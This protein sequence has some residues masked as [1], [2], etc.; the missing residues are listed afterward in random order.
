MRR[1]NRVRS[2]KAPVARNKEE[3]CVTKYCRNRKAL[4]T[5]YYTA[6]DG[7]KIVY[8]H[9][10]NH[11]W[12]CRARMLKERQPVTYV[13]NMLRHS[14]RKRNLPFTLTKAEFGKFCAET[15]YLEKRGNK[16]DSLTIDRKDWNEGYH[17]WN[18]QVMTHKDNSGQGCD[19][20]SREERGAAQAELPAD[21]PAE[22]PDDPF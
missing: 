22:E 21:P 15:G 17:I 10:L 20:T 8:K 18:L 9:Y 4:K 3:K 11:C 16:E 7:T 5:T 2:R 6:T 12:K 14:A 1:R 13:L 19:N